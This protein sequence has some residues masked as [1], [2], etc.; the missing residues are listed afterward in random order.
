MLLR[1]WITKETILPYA[2]FNVFLIS[3]AIEINSYFVNLQQVR[4]FLEMEKSK[5]KEEQMQRIFQSIPTSVFVLSDNKMVFS[6]KEGNNLVE[7]LFK[8]I[9]GAYKVTQS[10]QFDSTILLPEEDDKMMTFFLNS[11]IFKKRDLS[12]QRG[13]LRSKDELFS[14]T[15][16]IKYEDL[17][18]GVQ[19]ETEFEK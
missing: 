11:Q 7:T 9:Q 14:L 4:L 10:D 3:F 15:D 16:I 1:R 5:R 8:Q 13:S 6:N 17:E 12:S 2:L 18:E 19:F